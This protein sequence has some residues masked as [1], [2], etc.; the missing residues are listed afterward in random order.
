MTSKREANQ[1]ATMLRH[2]TLEKLQELRLDAMA[3]A[4]QDQI[5]HEEIGELDFMERLGLLVDR[6]ATERESRRLKTRLTKAKMR[7]SAAIEDINY[8]HSRGL[9]KALMTRLISCDWIR[10]HLNVLIT[11]S[12][13]LGKTW[14]GCA[15]AHKACREGF[16]VRYLRV[17]RMFGELEVAKGDGRYGK[18]LAAWAKIDLLVL[19]DLALVPLTDGNRRDL[20]EIL[21][22]RH[23]IRS[24][25][26]TSQIPVEKWHEAIGD[27]TL[28]DAILDRL[29]HNAHRIKLEGES[30]RKNKSASS[31][32]RT[33]AV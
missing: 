26:V 7:Q 15:L 11:G 25:L 22:D 9:D 21:E 27:P 29:V 28:A 13:G 33:A 5:D 30:I 14:L 12:T 4:L 24:T 10:K 20:L 18:L 23:G 6:E 3:R 32:T 2:P 31:R 1:E 8:R 19:D 16:R 17:P